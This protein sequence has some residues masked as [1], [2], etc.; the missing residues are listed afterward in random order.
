MAEVDSAW[1]R[2][3][4]FCGDDL[5]LRVR[6][7]RVSGRVRGEL[8]CEDFVLERLAP[9]QILALACGDP[10]PLPRVSR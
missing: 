1:E 8:R 4:G 6:V 10:L 5:E 3:A 2:S 9:S 7:G